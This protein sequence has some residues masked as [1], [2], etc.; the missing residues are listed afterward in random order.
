MVPPQ[1]T[2]YAASWDRAR[3]ASCIGLSRL[4]LLIVQ[5]SRSERNSAPWLRCLA[6]NGSSLK[7]RMGVYWFSSSRYSYIT[8]QFTT[9]TLSSQCEIQKKC[10]FCIYPQLVKSLD[11]AVMNNNCYH[12][13]DFAKRCWQSGSGKEPL[14]QLGENR[15][16][17]EVKGDGLPISILKE[18]KI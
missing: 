2:A 13:S 8:L 4:R 3:S 16:S 5:Q 6:P 15:D 17:C 9:F 1:F 10:S 7:K 12:M 14:L 18:A 11:L